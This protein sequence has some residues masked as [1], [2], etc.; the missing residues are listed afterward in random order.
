MIQISYAC[1]VSVPGLQWI[2]LCSAEIIKLQVINISCLCFLI[3]LQ[4][5]FPI[6]RGEQ[7]MAHQGI[8]SSPTWAVPQLQLAQLQ[9]AA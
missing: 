4:V 6:A 2:N 8:L 5:I 1:L 3:R 9:G 7:N